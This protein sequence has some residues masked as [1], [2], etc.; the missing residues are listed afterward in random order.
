MSEITGSTSVDSG[1]NKMYQKDINNDKRDKYLEDMKHGIPSVDSF[2]EHIQ[3]INKDEVYEIAVDPRMVGKAI[4]DTIINFGEVNI[5]VHTVSRDEL[6]KLKTTLKARQA[7][8]EKTLFGDR[9]ATPQRDD[10]Q[11]K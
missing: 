4:C 9:T 11:E 8:Q 2:C 5:P 3:D 7:A 6:E 1:K 10:G